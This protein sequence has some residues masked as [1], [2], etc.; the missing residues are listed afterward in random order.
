M[1]A[2]GRRVIVAR[3]LIIY[4]AV[5]LT[6]VLLWPVLDNFGVSSLPGDFVAEFGTHRITVPFASS[7]VA[8]VFIGAALWLASR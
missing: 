5:T 3:V 2:N 8:S 7:A 6:L 1:I 4:G